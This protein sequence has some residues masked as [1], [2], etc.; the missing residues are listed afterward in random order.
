MEPIDVATTSVAGS[1]AVS[2]TS[3]DATSLQVISLEGFNPS[4]GFAVGDAGLPTQSLLYY[5]A[6]DASASFL[7]DIEPPVLGWGAETQCAHRSHLRTRAEG[8]RP[9]GGNPPRKRYSRRLGQLLSRGVVRHKL[10][11]PVGPER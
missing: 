1:E 2:V 9:R 11:G 6:V 10:R 8:V 3:A 5:S 7:S 4:G